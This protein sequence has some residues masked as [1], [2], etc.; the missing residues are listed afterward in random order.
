[1]AREKIEGGKRASGRR[2]IEKEISLSVRKNGYGVGGAQRWAL[3][4]RF[5]QESW[6]KASTTDFVSVEIDRDEQRLYFVTSNK[7]EGYKLTG[8]KNVREIKPTIYDEIGW[9]KYGGD[10][11]L[12][13][14]VKSGDYYID[15]KALEDY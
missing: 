10:Y 7:N 1:M 6:K 9:R 2:N 11:N 12:L 14:D 5:A 3:S 8:N 15:L 13:K 4:I